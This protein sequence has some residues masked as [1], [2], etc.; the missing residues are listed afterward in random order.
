MT[1]AA[2]QDHIIEL[3]LAQKWNGRVKKA[4]AKKWDIHIRTVGDDAIV[5]SGVLARRGKP[6]E[7][8]IDL[9]MQELEHIQRVAM[10]RKRAVHVSD[11]EAGSHL[12]YVADPDCNAA[13][14]AIQTQL[15]M[16]GA[17][18]KARTG[19][20][21]PTSHADLEKLSAQERIAML[22][23]AIAEEESKL[24]GATH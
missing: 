24:K 7:E 10:E 1:P 16:R 8:L 5:A 19:A 23:S 2:R 3:L 14:K 20:D 21:A 9:K 17:G 11:G 6:I 13:I 4:L 15:E 22:K 12:E 18:T